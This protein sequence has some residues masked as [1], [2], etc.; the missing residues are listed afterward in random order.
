MI[1]Y[2]EDG[3]EQGKGT[4]LMQCMQTRT[5]REGTAEMRI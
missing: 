5:K 2:N 1:R 3:Q 4:R